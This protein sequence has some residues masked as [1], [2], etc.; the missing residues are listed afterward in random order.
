MRRQRRVSYTFR[1]VARQKCQCPFIEYCDWDRDGAM[2]IPDDDKFGASI[3]HQ[4][5]STVSRFSIN[6]FRAYLIDLVDVG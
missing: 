2:K 3:E 1:K 6:I 4:Y 5:V